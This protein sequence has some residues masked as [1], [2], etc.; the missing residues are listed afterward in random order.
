MEMSGAIE[1]EAG[2]DMT[3]TQDAKGIIRAKQSA[4]GIDI[5]LVLAPSPDRPGVV[6]ANTQQDG[7][8][9][10]NGVRFTYHHELAAVLSGDELWIAD[11]TVTDDPGTFQGEKLPVTPPQTS[12]F[13]LHRVTP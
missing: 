13:R 6:A 11:Y 12:L 9:L 1:G 2:T 4:M 10:P 8:T 5:T 3:V 7:Q